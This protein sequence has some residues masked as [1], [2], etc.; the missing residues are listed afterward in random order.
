MSSRTVS[1]LTSLWLI[2][3]T[4]W[5]LAC[6]AKAVQGDASMAI[7]YFTLALVSLGIAMYFYKKVKK[8]NPIQVK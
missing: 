4:I 2:V 8:K 1:F 6:N 5:A 7:I 3:A